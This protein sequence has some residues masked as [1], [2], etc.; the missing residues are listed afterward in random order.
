MKDAFCI[1]Y[2]K[3]KSN[4]TYSQ[5]FYGYQIHYE[6]CISNVDQLI[7]DRDNAYKVEQEKK[8][9]AEIRKK[10]Y[11]QGRKEYLINELENLFE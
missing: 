4:F 3:N 10:N 11:R 9:Q 7:W 2:A 8:R 6:Y 5:S 1:D